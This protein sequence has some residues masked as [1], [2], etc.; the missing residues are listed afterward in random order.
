MTGK[1]ESR[2][3]YK[4]NEYRDTKAFCDQC[5][6]TTTWRKHPLDEASHCIQCGSQRSRLTKHQADTKQKRKQGELFT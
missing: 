6:R 3:A 1:G 4:T 2:H 5:S